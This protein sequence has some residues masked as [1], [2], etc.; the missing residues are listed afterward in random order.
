MNALEYTISITQIATMHVVR[1]LV[2][3]HK[4][5]NQMINLLDTVDP[6]I[7]Y[8]LLYIYISTKLS[9]V[10]NSK[11]EYITLINA[12]VTNE[13]PHY[14]LKLSKDITDTKCNYYDVVK[15]PESYSIMTNLYKNIISDIDLDK[16]A[17]EFEKELP[18]YKEFK[19]DKECAEI[20]NEIIT[21]SVYR[22]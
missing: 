9:D 16:I 4:L 13:F 3:E 21:D 15:N 5:P 12:L 6:K 22:I 7:R 2:N 14:L 17:K 1:K 11:E 10:L 18:K 8:M 20:A 19:Y